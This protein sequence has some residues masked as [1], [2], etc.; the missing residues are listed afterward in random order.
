MIGRL[1]RRKGAGT[2][3][4]LREPP[5]WMIWCWWG[6]P[7]L[8]LFDRLMGVLQWLDDCREIRFV[9]S[10]P[11]AADAPGGYGCTAEPYQEAKSAGD[12]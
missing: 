9:V 4:A 11:E 2:G 5:Y 1:F 10:D 7:F 12:K 6:R 8:W 3:F